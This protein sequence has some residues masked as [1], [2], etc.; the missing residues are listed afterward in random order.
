MAMYGY[1]W[2]CV[3]G[4]VCEKSFCNDHLLRIKT[5][6]ESLLWRKSSF[7]LGSKNADDERKM[8]SLKGKM[9]M[10][11]KRHL[12]EHDGGWSPKKDVKLGLKAKFN[13]RLAKNLPDTRR[14]NHLTT[15]FNFPKKFSTQFACNL[16][17]DARYK[18]RG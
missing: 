13:F 10:S 11:R 9:R 12:Q 5:S 8:E 6:G 17:V 7:E 14:N 1:V 4:Y 3:Y 2:P 18:N 15:P 16:I